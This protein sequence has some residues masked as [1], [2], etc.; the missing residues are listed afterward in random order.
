MLINPV[1]SIIGII[2]C[3]EQYVLRGH[4]I[5]GNTCLVHW[6]TKDSV[7]LLFKGWGCKENQPGCLYLCNPQQ[8]SSY[9][10]FFAQFCG[11]RHLPNKS[12]I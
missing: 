5:I 4:E 10:S 9:I 7:F 3:S 12:E 2:S 8:N 1:I 6:G 11:L